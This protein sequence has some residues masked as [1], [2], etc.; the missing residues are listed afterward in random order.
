MPDSRM[1]FFIASSHVPSRSCLSAMY[2]YLAGSWGTLEPHLLPSIFISS[3]AQ[4]QLRMRRLGWSVS[5]VLY[6]HYLPVGM[7]GRAPRYL[8]D[9]PPSPTCLVCSLRTLRPVL[10]SLPPNCA[11]CSR[12]ARV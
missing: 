8:P 2:R 10:A 12:M 1:S 11:S 5:E 7:P 4:Q 3:D 6:T 9:A